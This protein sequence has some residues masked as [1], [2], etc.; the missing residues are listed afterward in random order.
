MNSFARASEKDSGHPA[1]NQARPTYRGTSLIRP[2]PPVGPYSSPMPRDLGGWVFLMSE[3]PCRVVRSTRTRLPASEAVPHVVPI[4]DALL[5][6]FLP[7][8]KGPSA[9]TPNTV[10]LIPT[11]GVLSPPRRARPGPGPHRAERERGAAAAMVITAVV[12]RAP[13]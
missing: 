4:C 1:F 5:T 13:P 7:E 9:L 3:V 6:G 12:I 11:L 10:E 2:P 8:D